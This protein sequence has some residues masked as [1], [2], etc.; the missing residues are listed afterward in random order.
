VSGDLIVVADPYWV[1]GK[2]IGTTHGTPYA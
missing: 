1:S 2:A